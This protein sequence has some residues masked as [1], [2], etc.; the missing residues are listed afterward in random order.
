MQ[1][2]TQVKA[3]ITSGGGTAWTDFLLKVGQLWSRV[4]ELEADIQDAGQR[5]SWRLRVADG[6][7][8]LGY[9]RTSHGGVPETIEGHLLRQLCEGGYPERFRSALFAI[10]GVRQTTFAA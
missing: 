2:T 7:E 3:A 6:K 10:A 9:L 4:Q 5:R 8:L 1:I